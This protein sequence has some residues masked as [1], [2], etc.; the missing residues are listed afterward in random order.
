MTIPLKKEPDDFAGKFRGCVEVCHF[1]ETPTKYWN[2]NTNNPVC[3]QCAKEHKVSELPDHGQRIR[4][5]K[6]RLRNN[7]GVF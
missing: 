3:Q 1:C 5:A 4:A 7:H 6:R 2:E